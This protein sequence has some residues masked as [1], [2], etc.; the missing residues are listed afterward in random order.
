MFQLNSPDIDYLTATTFNPVCLRYARQV[1][2]AQAR[3]ED[4]PKRRM[5]YTGSLWHHEEGTCYIGTGEQK[6]IEH[7]LIQVSGLWADSLWPVLRP[8]V[9]GGTA[10]VT[11][12]DLQIT[13]PYTRSTWSQVRLFER[14]KAQGRVSV[15]YRESQSGP[16]GSTLATVY[17]GSRQSDRF[18][19]VYEK[20][21][22]GEE[23]FLRFETEYK[24]HR[25]KAIALALD[26][27]DPAE[28]LWQEVSRV[29]DMVLESVF[30]PAL[31]KEERARVEVIK[32]EPA[33]VKWLIEQVAPALDRVIQDHNIDSTQV[34]ELFLRILNDA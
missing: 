13:C 5:Q 6:G 3:K 7:H 32:P 17:Y 31:G 11:R 22:M 20:M 33:T 18:I 4:T 19:R 16:A 8:F 27:T 24:G 12:L 1:V 9:V 25:A 23:V 34:R 29:S 26:D 28:I 30:L 21:G 14:L 2:I 15:S 10:N